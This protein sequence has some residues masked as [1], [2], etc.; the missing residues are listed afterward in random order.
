MDSMSG[1]PTRAGVLTGRNM[2]YQGQHV[3][4]TA[5]DTTQRLE[6][7]REL[8]LLRAAVSQAKGEVSDGSTASYY[9]LPQGCTELYELITHRD[10]NAQI[11][12]IFRA[13][14]RYGFVAH[15]SKLRDA[16]K[17]KFYIEAEIARLL[18]LEAKGEKR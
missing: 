2:Y 14:Y 11:G 9:V 17:I 5:A 6:I 16:K 12:E 8:D 10:M 3:G 4:E 15:S 1:T 18:K 7:M 13:C